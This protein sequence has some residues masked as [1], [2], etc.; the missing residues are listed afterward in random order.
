MRTS[1]RHTAS[2]VFNAVSSLTITALIVVTVIVLIMANSA[3]AQAPD[4]ANKQPV[5]PIHIVPMVRNPQGKTYQ[6]AT[7]THLS[8]FG[9]PVMSN[10]SVVTVFWTN[11][12]DAGVQ[13]T[14]PEFYSAI[15]NST[16]YDLLSEYATNVSPVGGGSGTSQSIGRGSSG[17]TFTISPSTCNDGT[18][19]TI[20]DTAIQTELLDQINAGH[21]PA[22]ELDNHGNVNTLY[23]I[24][25]PLNV[26]ITQGGSQSCVVFC[27]Y[28]GNTSLQFKLK[29]LEYGVF[30]DMGPSSSCF[31]GC[32]ADPN[33]LNDTTSVS[34]HEL[35]E[36]VTDAEV[37]LA[38]DFAPPLAWYDEI[39]GEIGDICNAE[40]GTVSAAGTTWTVQKLWSN[41]LN[42]CV[43]I[44]EHPV[45]QL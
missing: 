21:L 24:Y 12:V 30:P 9:G 8:Y 26:T 16:Y 4:E 41:A 29:N 3:A 36:A 33:Y 11:A 44:G 34:S 45:Y 6:P 18:S 7:G 37:G 27:T 32:G 5:R 25:F 31:G 28:H 35:A 38:T 22:P 39:N 1:S 13:T 2:I 43:T 42:N 40:Q 19:C 17:G 23:M 14:M 15:T 10:V 20:D